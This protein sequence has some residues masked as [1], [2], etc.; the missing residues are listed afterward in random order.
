MARG[1]AIVMLPI[2]LRMCHPGNLPYHATVVYKTSLTPTQR[3]PAWHELVT[4]NQGLTVNQRSGTIFF[5]ASNV[6]SK[7]VLERTLVLC[8]WIRGYPVES[9]ITQDSNEVASSLLTFDLALG[10]LKGSSHSIHLSILSFW[11]G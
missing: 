9:I 6:L 3:R 7:W 8:Q 4:P 1:D 11:N 5:S 10:A 2:L